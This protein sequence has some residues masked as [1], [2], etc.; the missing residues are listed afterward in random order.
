MEVRRETK[1]YDKNSPDFASRSIL[2]AARWSTLRC[3]SI[4]LLAFKAT[5]MAPPNGAEKVEQRARSF[6]KIR[7]ERQ[8]QTLELTLFGVW[9]HPICSPMVDF[10]VPLNLVSH[11]R[12]NIASPLNGAE[13][14]ERKIID[15]VGHGVG[16][17]RQKS[18][19]RTHRIL[20]IPASHLIYLE[21]T[22]SQ[23]PFLSP[24]A[25]INPAEKVEGTIIDE[26]LGD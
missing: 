5:I 18:K 9:R 12:V 23:L 11:L 21:A 3:H 16:R 1:F 8:N 20:H 10:A 2:S 13:K 14:V 22:L 24:P 7:S 19:I 6:M 4:A 26:G 17:E 15:E 25:P